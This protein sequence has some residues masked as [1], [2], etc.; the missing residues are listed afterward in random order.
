MRGT[1]ENRGIEVGGRR[2]TGRERL[3]AER[4]G[5]KLIEH[6][7]FT[8]GP[9]RGVRREILP[10]SPKTPRVAVRPLQPDKPGSHHGAHQGPKI[11]GRRARI[12]RSRGDC[13]GVLLPHEPYE[14]A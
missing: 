11:I 6:V 3:Q 8:R 14:I 4:K 2:E 1:N 9:Y 13:P 10:G 5:C 7:P 12:R